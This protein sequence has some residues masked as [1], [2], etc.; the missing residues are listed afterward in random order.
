MLLDND[1]VLKAACYAL[2]LETLAATTSGDTVPGMLGVGRFVIRRRVERAT[3]L[4]DRDQARA[5]LER[6]IAAVEVFEP[7]EDELALAADLEAEASRHGLELDGGESQ[8]LA[9]VVKRN[10][11]CLLTGDKRAISAMAAVAMALAAGR[12]LCFEQ[13]M[14]R[15]VAAV[16][17]DAVRPRVCAEPRV[18]RALTVCFGCARDAVSHA[19]VVDGL[20]SYI[21]HIERGAPGVLMRDAA[22]H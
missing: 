16:G 13:L 8:L 1:V 11:H 15:I 17:L 19:D 14:A 5:S 4:V 10:L 21:D 6:M 18:D 2:A 3:N 9:I 12:V 20:A 7:T 22:A